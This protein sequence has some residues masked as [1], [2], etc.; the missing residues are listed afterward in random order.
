MLHLRVGVEFE[1][2]QIGDGSEQVSKTVVAESTGRERENVLL[3]F[4]FWQQ[5]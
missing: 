5:T 4:F 1:S 2:G 3:L